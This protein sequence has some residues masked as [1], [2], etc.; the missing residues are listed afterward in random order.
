MRETGLKKNLIT[1]DLELK[2]K[3]IEYTPNLSIVR[4]CEL[5]ELNRSNYYYN[6]RKDL[7]TE[8]YKIMN[9]IDEIYTEHPYY[10]TRRMSYVL[11]S[12][13]INIGRKNV[14]K[15]YQIMGIEAIYPKMNLRD[16]SHL[17]LEYRKSYTML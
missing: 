13:G 15:Y 17:L 6:S 9:R 16:L 1:L 11:R 5:L 10:G 3:M 12:E 14:R 8:D 4:Q 2:K 7:S